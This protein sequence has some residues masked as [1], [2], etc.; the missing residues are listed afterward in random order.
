MHGWI[1]GLIDPFEFT[2][3]PGRFVCAD[4]FVDDAL[5]E[6]VRENTKAKACSYCSKKSARPIAAPLD[7][8]AKHILVCLKPRYEDAANGVGWDEGEYLGAQ[9]W[10]T[11]D[12]IEEEVELANEIGGALHSDLTNALPFQTWSRV[13]PYGPLRRDVFGWSWREFCE[14]VKHVRRFFFEEHLTPTRP[15]SDN[16][17]PVELLSKV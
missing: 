9:T 6:V 11:W 5:K 7:V 1:D 12:L 10:D 8:L 17:S 3:T 2:S 14:T 16:I 13:D 15:R 4:C